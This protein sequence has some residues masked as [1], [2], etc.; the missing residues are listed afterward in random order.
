MT[1]TPTARAEAAGRTAGAAAYQSRQPKAPAQCATCMR[2]VA[3]N[4]G[5]ALAILQA[6][7]AGYQAEIREAADAAVASLVQQPSRAHYPG[8]EPTVVTVTVTAETDIT[9]RPEADFWG[10]A[11]VIHSYSREEAIADGVLVDAQLGDFADVTRQHHGPTPVAMTAALFALIEKAVAHPRH[12]NDFAGVW[13]DICWMSRGALRNA[14]AGE[15]RRFRV[16]IT[17]TGRRKYH[18]LVAVW[19]GEAVTYM[20]PNED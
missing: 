5:D 12:C 13:H 18:D 10:D 4:D 8:S 11:E 17:G 1:T 19:D 2:L 3:E 20:L 16:I 6:W 15:R 7:N 14:P 9:A